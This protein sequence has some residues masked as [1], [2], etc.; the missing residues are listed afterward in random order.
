MMTIIPDAVNFL[1][2]HF[3]KLFFFHHEF[4]KVL[5]TYHS[6]DATRLVTGI[7]Y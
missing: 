1:K 5:R 6:R 2:T 3:N 4:E 7:I